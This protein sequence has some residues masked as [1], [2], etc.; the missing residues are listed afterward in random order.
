MA[1]AVEFT[2]E[3]P[4]P[5][6]ENKPTLLDEEGEG[7]TDQRG[8]EVGGRVAFGVFERI[9][10]GYE[11]RQASYDVLPNRRI[12]SFVDGESS[13]G[14]RI[15]E[16]DEPRAGRSRLRQFI[17]IWCNIDEFHLSIGGH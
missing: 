6:A 4:L 2:E 13:G 8:H 17:Y 5:L 14:V 16:M 9:V 11:R 7:R 15:E 10:H 12:R 3:N 1:G